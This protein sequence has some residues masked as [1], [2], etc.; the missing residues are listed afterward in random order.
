MRE[1]MNIVRA[2]GD[3]N[4]VRALLALRNR[5]LCV[6]Q[7]IE[8]LGLAPSTASKHMSI[9]KQ[10]RLVDTRKSGRWVLYRLAGN[11]SA[12]EVQEAIAWLCKSLS[13]DTLVRWDERRLKEILKMDRTVLCSAQGRKAND[14]CLTQAAGSDACDKPLWR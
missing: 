12:P 9:L 2:L 10:A 8:F 13:K 7:L 4:R 11:K 3:E 6:C 1:F 14:R 5:E